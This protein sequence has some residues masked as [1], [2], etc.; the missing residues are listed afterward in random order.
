MKWS[1]SFISEKDFYNHVQD[2]IKKY[3]E[4]LESFDLKRF[5]KNL[6]DPIKLLFDK[7]VYQSDWEE[8][9]AIAKEIN[10]QS[11]DLSV[12]M[13]VYMLGFGSYNGFAK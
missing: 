10:I 1:L 4:K 8:L 11:D 7:T 9:Q 13:A 6:I 3:G 2:A 5:N 12:A